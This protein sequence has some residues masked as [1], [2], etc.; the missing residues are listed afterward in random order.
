MGQQEEFSIYCW[1]TWVFHVPVRRYARVDHPF[2][3]L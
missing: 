2:S 3:R 1:S